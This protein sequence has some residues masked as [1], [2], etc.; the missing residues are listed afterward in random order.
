MTGVASFRTRIDV[1]PGKGP[2]AD[3]LKLDG[4]FDISSA[5]FSKLDVQSK[6]ATLS[7]RGR[8]LTKDESSGSVVS[9]FAGKFVLGDG[10]MTF[11]NLTFGVPG[12]FV[13]LDGTYALHDEDIDFR[14]SLRLQA[15]LSQTTRG[16]KSKLLKPFDPLFEKHGAG[17]FV[18]IRI[19]GTG[20]DP[21]FGVDVRHMF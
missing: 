1:P 17:T 6:V 4:E 12:A 10:V 9:D 20:S 16:W 19:T 2:V 3:R 14:G 8:G 21:H 11:S 15:T 18:P 5:R 7:H 13:H